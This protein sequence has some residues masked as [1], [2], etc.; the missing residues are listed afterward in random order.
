MHFRITGDTDA[1]ADLGPVI[2]D[3]SGPA[4]QH[5]LRREYGDGLHGLVV[6]LVCRDPALHFKQRVR[7]SKND[8]TLYLDVMLDL[9]EMK[10]A[11]PLER[12]S[13]AARRLVEE[14]SA[15]LQKRKINGFD[16][17]RFLEDLRYWLALQDPTLDQSPSN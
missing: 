9:P 15:A 14:V 3:W 16:Q 2:T 13:V 7:F 11:G 17:E 5:F 12:K 10:Q 6:V 4:R 1:A 8:R